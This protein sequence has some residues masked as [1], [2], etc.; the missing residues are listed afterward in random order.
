MHSVSVEIIKLELNVP[1]ECDECSHQ[2]MESIL[3]KTDLIKKGIE[4]LHNIKAHK[5]AQTK[6]ESLRN[7]SRPIEVKNGPKIL[8]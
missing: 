6:W 2:L 3:P 4:D 8:V 5:L 1:S 7:E